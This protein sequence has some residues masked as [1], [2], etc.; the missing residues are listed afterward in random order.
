M[1]AIINQAKGYTAGQGL[2]NPTLYTLA[3]TPATYA[4][5]FHDIT[6]GGNTCL[7]GTNYCNGGLTSTDYVSTTGYDQ[8]SGLGS[9]D[10]YNLLTAWPKNTVAGGSNFTISNAT[11]M[12]ATPGT[13]ASANFTITPVGGYTGSVA[14]RIYSTAPVAYTCFSIPTA[15][16]TSAAAV[17]ATVTIST[18]ISAC[19]SGTIPLVITATGG[20]VASA[21]PPAPAAPHHNPAPISA[22]VA[23]LL[24]LGLLSRRSR[25]KL[26]RTSLAL[27]LLAIMAISGL[28][29]SGCSNGA[30]GATTTTTTTTT[31]V[32]T[33]AGGPYTITVVGYNPSNT[34]QSATA[35]LTLTVQ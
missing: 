6:S 1:L 34:S 10:L 5:A 8:A 22:A 31:N 33:P 7:A 24:C 12:V 21:Q 26:A 17:T 32:I 19:G 13:N 9:V 28:G 3:S 23:G 18:N 20:P 4:S 30:S 11:V 29:L 27:G 16:I 14:F 25:S 2:V 35:T 15:S